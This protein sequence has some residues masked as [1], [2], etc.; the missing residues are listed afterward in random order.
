MAGIYFSGTGNSKYCIY[1]FLEEYDNSC[2]AFSME[3][4]EPMEQTKKNEEIVISYP[5]QF[6]NIPKILYDYIIAN[7]GLPQIGQQDNNR[8]TAII[9]YI[10]TTPIIIIY[11]LKE[12]LIKI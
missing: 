6:S 11:Q 2:P 3:Q 8:I 1:K 12:I 4:G 9:C 5:V 10:S 7:Q